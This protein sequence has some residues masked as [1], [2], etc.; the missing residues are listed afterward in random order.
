LTRF[1]RPA[2]DRL[3]NRTRVLALLLTVFCMASATKLR[4]AQ[5]PVK[6]VRL[7]VPLAPGGSVDTVARLVAARLS[8]KFGQQFVVDNRPGAG[9]TVGIT[10][11]ARA[12]PDGYTL[13]MMSSAFA[14]NPA[15]YKL[16]YD[17]VKDI[18]PV[19]LMAAGPMFLAVH[20]AVK[21]ASLK[22]FIAL[23][24]AS[25]GALN[26]G[27]GGT[28]SATHLATELFRQMTHTSLVHVPYKGIG[29]AIADLLG[30]QIQFYIAPGAGLLPYTSTNRLRLLAVTGE[31]RSRDLP[32]VPAI[33]ELVPGYAADFWYGLGAPSG[34][35]KEI[36]TLLNQELAQILKQPDLLKRLRTFDLEPAHAAP[37]DFTRRIAREMA[38]WAK[39][40]K[41][42]NIRLE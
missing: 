5:W 18:A 4:A 16:P 25:P 7:I 36:I 11:V 2:Q 24:R 15:L 31:Q 23:A 27:S 41:A 28:G 21:A 22:E 1:T 9:A 3:M 30:G 38:M 34:T 42:A 32:E 26:Y 40:V 14:A 37:E 33:N 10:L 39:V 19:G 6:P 35:P 20:P 8:D 12:N 29:A 17:P 13:L